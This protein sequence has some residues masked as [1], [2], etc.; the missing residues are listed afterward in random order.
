MQILKQYPPARPVL[1]TPE[2]ADEWLEKN[3]GNRPQRKFGID[4]Y[5]RMMQEGKWHL[6]PD[7]IAFDREGVLRNGA[8][9]LESVKRSG[10]PQP[11][12]V[13]EGLEPEAF[14]FMDSGFKRLLADH[15]AG[16]GFK[17]YVSVASIAKVIGNIAR[18]GIVSRHLVGSS[19]SNNQLDMDEYIEYAESYKDELEE[20]ARFIIPLQQRNPG[21][22]M[23]AVA[24]TI[25]ALYSREHNIEP[26]LEAVHEGIGIEDTRS[27]AHLLRRRL[28]PPQDLSVRG[29]QSAKMP[30]Y[31]QMAYATLAANLFVKGEKRTMLKWVPTRDNPFP[32]PNV[33]LTFWRERMPQWS[34][35]GE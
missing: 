22:L 17:C 3:I 20:A 27:P 6:M 4:K 19:A 30:R 2:L 29:Q 25:H 34:E 23:G 15:L 35:S 24:G 10:I 32:Q 18:A 21:V 33:D 7:M 12:Y 31:E 16:L 26:F 28:V 13:V 11:F 1:V 9:R 14:A 8:H 5:V